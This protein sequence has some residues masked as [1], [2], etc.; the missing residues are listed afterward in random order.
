MP[1]F[2]NQGNQKPYFKNDLEN[3][4]EKGNFSRVGEQA[5]YIY[6]SLF[7]NSRYYGGWQKALS[8]KDI[9]VLTKEKIPQKRN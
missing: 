7:L 9:R 5:C 4:S 8:R 3:Q 2:P 1:N 6:N